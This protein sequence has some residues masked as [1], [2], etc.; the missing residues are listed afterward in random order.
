MEPAE[1]A[2]EATLVPYKP[3]K[4]LQRSQ[5]MLS[6]AFERQ[7]MLSAGTVSVTSTN[8]PDQCQATRSL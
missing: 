3:D 2:P 6:S 5:E 7:L 8:R 4:P 1:N